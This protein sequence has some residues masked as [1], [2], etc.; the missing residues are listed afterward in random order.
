[1]RHPVCL[2][3]SNGIVTQTDLVDCNSIKSWGAER[4]Q[5]LLGRDSLHTPRPYVSFL[6]PFYAVLINPSTTL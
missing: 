1:M 3:I 2:P 5:S 6:E 4:A